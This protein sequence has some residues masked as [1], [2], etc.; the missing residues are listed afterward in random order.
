M[1]KNRMMRLASILLVAVLLSTSVISGTFAKYTNTAEKKSEA[2]VAKWDFEIGT[3]DNVAKIQSAT[4][5][6]DLFESVNDSNVK[7]GSG[8]NIIAPGTEGSFDLVLSNK[9]EVTAKYAL[10]YTVVN[11]GVPL[12]YSVDGGQS[13][14][15][16]IDN[17]AADDSA[18]KLDMETGSKTITVQ[19]RWLY[20]TKDSN[21]NITGDGTDTTLGIAGNAKPSVTVQVT[22][23]QVD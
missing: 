7:T 10:N 23:T 9:S 14:S 6:F 21:G 11:A 18:T 15:N 19:W 20:E 16:T 5:T 22:A 8:E 17:V 4:F 3:G 1:K 12:E 2:R 13:W